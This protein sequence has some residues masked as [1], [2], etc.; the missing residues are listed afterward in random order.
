MSGAAGS[1]LRYRMSWSGAV[2]VLAL[3]VSS[4]TRASH[5]KCPWQVRAERK[6]VMFVLAASCFVVHLLEA[7]LEL[8][9]ALR[10]AFDE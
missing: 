5:V 9:A 1:R 4:R 6:F 8:R 7:M 10:A 2:E 3:G